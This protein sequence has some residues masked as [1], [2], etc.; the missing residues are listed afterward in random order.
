MWAAEGSR[1][2]WICSQCIGLGKL[3]TFWDKSWGLSRD[4]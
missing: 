4:I 2:D 3:N 1:Q